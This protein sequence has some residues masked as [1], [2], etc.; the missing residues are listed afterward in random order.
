VSKISD[1]DDVLSAE[2][3]AFSQAVPDSATSCAAGRR[4]SAR[5]AARPENV[6]YVTLAR[7]MLTYSASRPLLSS[8]T[9]ANSFL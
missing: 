8:D 6:N 2:I 5:T 1:T 4:S 3:V 7:Q 9:H